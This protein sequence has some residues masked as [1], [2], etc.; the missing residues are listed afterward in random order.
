MGAVD[1]IG[2]EMAFEADGACPS[3]TGGPQGSG[4]SAVGI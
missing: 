4:G 1:G 2:F 3:T